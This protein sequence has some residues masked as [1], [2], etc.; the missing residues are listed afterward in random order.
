[1]MKLTKH[2]HACVRLEKDGKTLVIDP[3]VFTDPSALDGADVV[4]I[5]H[6]HSDHVDRARL[7]RAAPDLEVW[8]SAAVADELAGLPA[9]LHV[10][11]D[12]D[13]F[14]TA[15]FV[16]QVVG[17]WHA[18]GHPDVPI[19]SNIGFLVDDE[20]FY[21]G[22]AFTIPDAPVPT[23]LLPTHAPWMRGREMVE[24]LRAIR[25]VRAYS[26]H[27]GMLNEYGLGVVD[28]W[29]ALEAER[30]E[31]DIRRLAVGESVDLG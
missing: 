3:G 23:L 4:L 13:R 22:D 31:A 1:M 9:R 28:G 27:D 18:P 30:H 24:Y 21:P 12:G 6:R 26:T 17:E 20:V 7:E 5:T 15:G 8:T 11:A 14:D 10:V 2:G 29:L 16:V 19:A 25:P